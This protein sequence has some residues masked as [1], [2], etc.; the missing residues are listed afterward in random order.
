MI[1]CKLIHLY[2]FHELNL[3]IPLQVGRGCTVVN[4]LK[5]NNYTFK[6]EM[7]C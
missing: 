1:I 5:T 6:K 4:R 2:A 3:I 7:I